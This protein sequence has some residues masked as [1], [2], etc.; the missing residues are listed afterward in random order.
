[1]LMSEARQDSSRFVL[2]NVIYNISNTYFS[3]NSIAKMKTNNNQTRRWKYLLLTS[4]L[5][6]LMLIGI[7]YIAESS[8]HVFGMA[9]ERRNLITLDDKSHPDYWARTSWANT[10][11]KLHSEFDIAFFGNSI[12][13]G[14]DFQ[15]AFPDKRIINLGYSGDNIIGMRHRVSMLKKANPKKIFLMAGTNDIFHINPD[16]LIERYT[17]LLTVIQDSLPQSRIYIQSILPMN[18]SMKRGA[19]DDTKIRLANK[20]LKELAD[21]K[22]IPFINLYDKYATTDGIL[23]SKFTK[24]GIHLYPQ[25]YDKWAEAIRQYVYE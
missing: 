2:Y 20:N 7:I 24:D 13:R 9:L 12:T 22:S 1:M 17:Q 14:S 5:I 8:G 10:I 18:P 4:L 19:P 11:A 25:Y 23:P 16:E 21:S 15:S 6:N 3:L